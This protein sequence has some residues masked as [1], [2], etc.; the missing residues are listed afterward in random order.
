[1]ANKENLLKL[2]EALESGTYPQAR[3][4]WGA[5]SFEGHQTPA[6][7]GQE[8]KGFC[9]MHVALA[10]ATNTASLSGNMFTRSR[11]ARADATSWLGI[12][13]GG[14]ADFVTLNDKEGKTFPEIAQYIRDT[15]LAD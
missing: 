9:C 5:G 6:L 11:N 15:Y 8:E 1:M 12:D 10:L 13:E 14:F 7:Y 2:A 4:S 3:G